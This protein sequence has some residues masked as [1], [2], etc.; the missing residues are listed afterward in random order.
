MSML[1]YFVGFILFLNSGLL[2][3]QISPGPLVEYHKELEGLFN[4]T[5]CHTLGQKISDEKCLDCHE[6]LRSRIDAGKGYHVSDVVTS[7]NCFE[8]HSDHHGRKFD[9]IRFDESEFDHDLTGYELLGAHQDPK[10]ADCHKDAHISKKEIRDKVYTYLGL[11]TECLSCHDDYHRSELGT[12]CIDCHDFE[13]FVP[14]PKF[15]HNDTDFRLIGAHKE[16]DCVSCHAIEGSGEDRFQQFTGLAFDNCTSCH[17]DVHQGKFGN[18]CTDCHNQNSF[19]E[20]SGRKNFDHS[21]TNFPLLGQHRFLDC[22]ECHDRQNSASTMFEDFQHQNFNHCTTCHEDVHNNKFGQD[23]RKCHSEESFKQLNDPDAFD[24][25][26]TDYPLIGMHIEVD[27]AACHIS[28]DMTDPLEH[29]ECKSCHD[30]YHQ[31][32]FV[33]TN[34]QS[35]DCASCHQVE[36]GFENTHFDID[37]HKNTDFPLTGAHIATPCFVCHLQSEDRWEFRNIGKLCVDCHDD[38]HYQYIDSAYYPKQDCQACHS[39]EAWADID[40]DHSRT[41]F[42]LEG[43]HARSDCRACHMDGED[44]NQ[45]NQEFKGLDA[46]CL[47]CHENVHYGQFDHLG[48]KNCNNCHGFEDWTASRFDHDNTK[49]RLEGAHQDLECAACHKTIIRDSTELILYKIEKFEC[50]DCHGS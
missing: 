27:C 17:E 50:V 25:S 4:C 28:E 42:E 1:K 33:D 29:E 36:E 39:T 37:D 18:K 35:P 44:Q 43:A 46:D 31:G 13:A 11:S 47:H 16:L 9:I 32:D 22:F 41:D 48:E 26:L 12:S 49:F 19:S 45:L 6:L 40:F 38:I 2:Y 30:D 14:A 15:D 24:H 10:C 20:I 8:C 21:T 23:C 7:I 5:E 34:G 3:T